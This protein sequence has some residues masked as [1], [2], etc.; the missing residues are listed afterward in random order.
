MPRKKRSDDSEFGMVSRGIENILRLLNE[1]LRTGEAKQA[2]EIK[3]LGGI[4]GTRIVYNLSVKTLADDQPDQ[5]KLPT[6]P[7]MDIGS[8]IK[9]GRREPLIDIIDEGE[10]VTLITEFRGVGDEGVDLKIV[11]NKL[12]ISSGDPS[13][14]CY[15]EIPL[16]ATVDPEKIEATYRNGILQVRVDKV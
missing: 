4:K 1:A 13:R 7:S 15:R 9:E 5:V 8:L 11:G 10:Y 12:V 6:R 14:G 3:D 2:G 16:P